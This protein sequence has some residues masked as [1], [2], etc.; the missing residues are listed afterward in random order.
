MTLGLSR[1][2][3]Q[4]GDQA[5]KMSRSAGEAQWPGTAPGAHPKGRLV[6]T[7]RSLRESTLPPNMGHRRVAGWNL[8]RPVPH[9]EML[10]V[11]GLGRRGLAEGGALPL[12]LHP[13]QILHTQEAGSEARH[14]P[15]LRC[16][17]VDLLHRSCLN[18]IL[19]KETAWFVVTRSFRPVLS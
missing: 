14:L 17:P 13:W 1:T 7:R 19:G 16:L 9:P 3:R 11:Q 8:N 5:S 2:G 6:R 18:S 4:A 12:A 10:W 15:H